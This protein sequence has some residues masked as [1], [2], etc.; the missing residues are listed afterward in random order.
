MD[1]VVK[2]LQTNTNDTEQESG[3][4]KDLARDIIISHLDTYHNNRI[5]QIKDGKQIVGT[6]REFRRAESNITDSSVREKLYLL[7]MYE[8]ESVSVFCNR[9]ESIIRQFKTCDT[10]APLTE[11]E[12]RSAS[13]KAMSQNCTEVR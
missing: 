4:K 1:V 7:N 10:T 9:F 11:E 8:K 6:I 12:K 3:D 2:S 5:I 13:L